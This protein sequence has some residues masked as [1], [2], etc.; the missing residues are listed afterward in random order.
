MKRPGVIVIAVLGALLAGLLVYG[1]VQRG[2]DRT[3]DAAVRDGQRPAAP[4]HA[5]PRLDGPGT[6]VARRLPRAGRRPEL[7]GLVVRAVPRGGA[8]AAALP[9]HARRPRHGARRHLQGRRRRQRGASSAQLRPHLPEPARLPAAARARLRH[10]GAAR[11]LRDRRD[12]A[13]SSRC[14]AARSPR[15]SSTTRSRRRPREARRLLVL[16]ALLAAAGAAPPA[17]AA[18]SF[19]DVENELMCDTC[20][21]PLAIAESTRADQERRADPPPD[22]PGQDQAG[23]PR[24]LRRRVRAQRPDPPDRRRR[25]GRRLGGAGGDHR[26]PR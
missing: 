21:V 6:R 7:L 12:A 22:R 20:N 23:D 25:R 24:H 3:L 10:A 15:R 17:Q 4:D 2:D 8:A 16:L 18:T 13:G 9:A 19:N 11:D 14:R 5:L 26:S 1:L